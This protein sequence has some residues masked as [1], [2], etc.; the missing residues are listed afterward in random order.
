[1]QNNNTQNLF[2]RFALF[3]FYSTFYNMIKQDFNINTHSYIVYLFS[4]RI[5]NSIIYIYT[6]RERHFLLEKKFNKNLGMNENKLFLFLMYFLT[7]SW[8][9]V[10]VWC[11][12]VCCERWRWGV[13][14]CYCEQKQRPWQ[15]RS[16]R[17]QWLL[18]RGDADGGVA[19]CVVSRGMIGKEGE[20]RRRCQRPLCCCWSIGL[21]RERERGC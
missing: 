5:W 21:F 4:V 2:T 15:S 13:V 9:W 17:Q 11:R 7:E 19:G 1:M 10:G 6:E 18:C 20:D 16:G 12:L 14:D 3:Y 8:G